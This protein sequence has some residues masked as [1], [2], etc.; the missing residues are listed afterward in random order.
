MF[1][2]GVEQTEVT[3]VSEPEIEIE[4][5]DFEVKK[6]LIFHQSDYSL[7]R[8]IAGCQNLKDLET[9]KDEAAKATYIAHGLGIMDANITYI[10]DMAAHEIEEIFNEIIE[11]FSELEKQ[12]KKTFLFVYGAGAGVID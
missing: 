10:E 4:K 1:T 7:T 2:I 3:Q 12:G 5:D 6:A 11:E 9:T 8:L